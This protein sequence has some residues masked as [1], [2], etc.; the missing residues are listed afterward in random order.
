MISKGLK[1]LGFVVLILLVSCDN[2]EVCTQ[3]VRSTLNAGFYKV[4]EGEAVDSV[5][6]WVTVSAIGLGEN[7][8]TDSNGVKKIAFPLNFENNNTIFVITN[9]SIT[10]TLSVF[11][12]VSLNF[13]SYECGFAPVFGISNIMF[14]GNG[15]DSIHIIKPI[16]EPSE[17]E[18]IKIYL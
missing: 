14:T 15:F 4:V 17:D 16:A 6:N 3:N 5:M 10:D 13:V 7:I 11:Y 1:L 2:E 9:D 12:D 8:M 18:N